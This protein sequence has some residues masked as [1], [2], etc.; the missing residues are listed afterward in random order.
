MQ[1]EA[2]G[3]GIVVKVKNECKFEAS[4]NISETATP[5]P[6]LPGTSTQS[7]CTDSDGG[8]NYSVRGTVK[9]YNEDD[10]VRKITTVSDSC[11]GN[12]LY[13]WVCKNSEEYD[14]KIY[15]CPNKCSNGACV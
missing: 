13:E 5:P 14:D 6:Q 11:S 12:D 3:L 15:V 9:G 2:L 1:Q 8:V 10:T 7:I 4:S